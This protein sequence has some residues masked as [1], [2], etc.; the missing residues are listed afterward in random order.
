MNDNTLSFLLPTI[1]YS[2]FYILYVSSIFQHIS[3][4]IDRYSDFLIT[5]D[6]R[7]ACHGDETQIHTK[8]E[9]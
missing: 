2:L 3:D 1:H 7:W 9:M 6:R 4:D 5:L 8:Y